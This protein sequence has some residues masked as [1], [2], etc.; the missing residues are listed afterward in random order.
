MNRFLLALLALLTGLAA[1]VAPAQARMM[2][3]GEA[4]IGAVEVARGGAKAVASQVGI[5]EVTVPATQHRERD[6]R[7]R[8]IRPP[9]YIPSV[10][11]GVDRA[12]E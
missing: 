6:P 3:T 8:P 2:G 4:E 11:I 1:Q 9:I 12:L 10:Q 7:V 5:S